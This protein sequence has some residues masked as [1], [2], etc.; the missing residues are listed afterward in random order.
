[1]IFNTVYNLNC[2]RLKNIRGVLLMISK[3]I[4]VT[5]RILEI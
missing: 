1:M 2:N 3:N 5:I 4:S